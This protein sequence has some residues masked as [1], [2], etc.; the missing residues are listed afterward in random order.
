M[1][2]KN[3]N[4]DISFEEFLIKINLTKE[5]YMKFLK[6][7]KSGKVLVLKRNLKER[8][9]NNYN[10]EMILAWNANMDIQ[11]AIDPYAIISYIVSYVSKDES[12]VTK[13]LQEALKMNTS[14]DLQEKLKALKIAYL[15]HRQM[16]LAEAVN[17]ILSSMTL[18]G[19]NV[20]CIFVTTGFPESRSN[21]YWS[22][23][24]NQDNCNE[25]GEKGN[26]CN[27]E[28]EKANSDDEDVEE[29]IQGHG[30][31]DLVEIEGRAGKF[32]EATTVHDRYL[33]R[34]SDLDEMCLAQ[35]AICYTPIKKLPKGCKMT[36]DGISEERS[37]TQSMLRDAEKKLPK[38][39]QLKNNFGCMRLRTFP[40]V[41]RIHS[42]KKKEGHEKEYSEL[43][44]FAHWRDEEKDFY[45]DDAQECLN[46]YNTVRKDEIQDN[47]TKLFPGESTIETIPTTDLVVEK[48]TLVYDMIDPQTQ[49]DNEDDRAVG[50]CED[51]MFESHGY[52]GNL[53]ESKETSRQSIEEFKYKKVTLPA[54]DDILQI[55]RRLCSE[56]LLAVEKIVQFCKD[57]VKAR[58]NPNVTPKPVRIIIHGGAGA[59]KSATI[60]AISMIAE[61]ILRKP[62]DHP[63]HP[64]V[65]ICAPTGKAASLVDGVTLHSAFGFKF[66]TGQSIMSDQQLAEFRLN[67]SDLKIWI[68]D[69]MSMMD[70]DMM[71]KTHL[72]LKRIFQTEELD[73]F[74]N[75]CVV[76]VGDLLQLSPVKGSYIFKKP[77]FSDFASFHSVLPLWQTFEPVILQQNHRQGEQSI[78]AD[79]LNRFREGQLLDEDIEILKSR[80]S[81][82]EFLDENCIHVFYKN[83]DVKALNDKMLEKIDSPKVI[84]K[85]VKAGPKAYKANVTKHG[86]ID[87]TQFMDVLELKIGARCMVSFNVSLMDNLVNGSTGTVVGFEYRGKEVECVIIQFDDP[88]AGVEQR[89][90]YPNISSKYPNGTPIFRQQLE[91]QIVSRKGV[92]QANTAKVYQ[93]PLR[94][95]YAV[96]AHRI[97]GVTI[98]SGVKLIIHWPENPQDGMIYVMLG[99]IFLF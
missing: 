61:K 14:A 47:R 67:L 35:F 57:T 22:V 49:Q 91:Y 72:R 79:T 4:D 77:N 83:E 75:L 44:L 1:D 6:I 97:Q 64:R 31:K 55:L 39:L 45:I 19:S 16:G 98:P 3:F 65:L 12:G 85:A 92:K 88:M 54:D 26:N 8:F 46:Q 42:S 7:S 28:A 24:D 15:T 23:P 95:C 70:S 60:R 34:P 68:V 17:K 86:T 78:W 36:E 62:G 53:Q 25:E 52:T 41:L 21:F 43:L 50:P 81:K 59:G 93:F 32:K 18:R 40:A 71:Y 76:F 80:M 74:G 48:P 87:S 89:K 66:G 13:F 63:H 5:E 27:E 84:M 38:Y 96:T 9:V 90:K 94:I 11:L 69:E 2:D 30:D 99:K 51:P 73:P 58:N 56:Q 10:A 37:K 33:E 82:E 29:K 20:T